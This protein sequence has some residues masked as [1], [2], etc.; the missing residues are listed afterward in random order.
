[1]NFIFGFLNWFLILNLTDLSL[2]HWG[3]Q[4]SRFLVINIFLIAL[5][6]VRYRQFICWTF[7]WILSLFFW[8]FFKK[9]KR[10][11]FFLRTFLL[12]RVLTIFSFIIFSK[13]FFFLTL[14]CR[15]F[16]HWDLFLFRFASISFNAA[17]SS[18]LLC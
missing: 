17:A 7:L 14:N 3:L 18:N 16:T 12:R 9:T 11:Y 5:T 4:L 1:M 2:L 13:T 6:T 8:R 15:L 10:F